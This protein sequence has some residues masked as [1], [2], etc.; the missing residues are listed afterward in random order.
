[1]GMGKDLETVAKAVEE[2]IPL[3]EWSHKCIEELRQLI[4]Q[5]MESGDKPF[6]SLFIKE[7]KK[8]VREF[9]E[10]LSEGSIKIKPSMLKVLQMVSERESFVPMDLMPQVSQTYQVLKEMKAM[11]LIEFLGIEGRK[12]H[13]YMVSAMGQ[14][15]MRKLKGESSYLKYGDLRYHSRSFTININKGQIT[16]A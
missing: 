9:S 3:A 10:K 15:I 2:A 16:V 12:P 1:M 5:A 14:K 8:A 6:Q 13:I 11:G 7:L 4:Q